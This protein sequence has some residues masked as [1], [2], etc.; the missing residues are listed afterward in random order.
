MKFPTIKYIGQLFIIELK[1]DSG[2]YFTEYNEVIDEAIKKYKVGGFIFFEKNIIDK[3]QV[4]LLIKKLNQNSS[5]PLF[6]A[7]DE[8][9][10]T[11][12]RLKKILKKPFPSHSELGEKNDLD[13]TFATAFKIGSL[14]KNT[15]FNIDFAPV[16]DIIQD[17]NAYGAN[18][19]SKKNTMLKNRTFGSDIK[20]SIPH[21]YNFYKGLDESGII[22]CPKHFPG[23]GD[24]FNDLHKTNSFSMKT[25][26]DLLNFDVKPYKLL[27]KSGCN[28][29]MTG[30]N[31][32][33]KINE[34][35]L[36]GGKQI[37]TPSSLS[38]NINT[39][40]L[41]KKL[42]YKN[43]IITDSLRMKSIQNSFTSQTITNLALNAG[44]DILL[45]PENFKQYY[46]NVEHS[47]MI[48]DALINQNIAASISRILALKKTKIL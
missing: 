28:L 40:L 7:I 16:A 8:E 42:K 3:L 30:H 15:G 27:I 11:V 29:I 5:I 22:P 4:K 38:K 20:N 39:F 44:I 36:I 43:V 12:S 41:R 18:N 32:F 34:T 31:T 10:G 19:I 17:A 26:K 46:E 9:G 37:V 13:Y 35:I 25:E 1:S 47:A 21:C 23:C 2:E 33:S 45:M 14:L 48:P 24:A 6:L